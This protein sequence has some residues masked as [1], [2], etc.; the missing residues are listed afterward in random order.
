MWR[1]K[2]RVSQLDL[3]SSAGVSPRHL[4]FVETGRSKPSR[5]MVL[6]LAEQLDVPLRERNALLTAA[7]FAPLYRESALDAPELASV[8]QA[9]AVILS[10]HDPWP[11][12]VID[13]AW[14]LLEANSGVGGFLGLVAPELLEPPTNIIRASLHPQ[15][16]SRFIVNFDE[17]AAHVIERLRRQ[18]AATAD[19][20]LDALLREVSDYPDVAQS[21]ARTAVLPPPAAV[22]P[23]HFRLDDGTELRF[24]STMTVFGSPLDV[25][26]A[27]LAIESFFPADEVTEALFR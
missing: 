1:S 3:A 4:S 18:L 27:E 22:L 7:G 26:I 13:G 17:Y 5:E 15:G 19:P 6:H 12:F 14:N 2:R 20:G 10:G 23:M 9:I 11:A 24:F 16:L 8:R 25:T 21:L